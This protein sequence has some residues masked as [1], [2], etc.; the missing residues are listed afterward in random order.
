MRKLIPFILFFSFLLIGCNDGIENNEIYKGQLLN[1]AIIG[2][3]PEVREEN[4]K[5]TSVSLEEIAQNTKTISK[6]FNAVFIMPENFSKADEDTYIETY[7]NLEIP[8]FFIETTKA[9]LPFVTENVT[10][11]T[12]PEISEDLYAT[13]YLYSESTDGPKVDS[14]RFFLN[15]DLENSIK[16]KD[17]YTNIFKTIEKLSR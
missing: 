3:K 17:V 2:E 12:A 1:I 7:K 13:G 5:F 15:N 10:Y 14:W 8:V 9:H 6:K 11:E 4:I 16:I